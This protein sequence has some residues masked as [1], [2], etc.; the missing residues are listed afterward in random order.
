M[1]IEKE[2]LPKELIEI[3]DS[4]EYEE[5]GYLDVESFDFKDE[6]ILFKFSLYLGEEDLREY[7]D[8]Q[9]EIKNYKDFNINFDNLNGYFKFHTNHIALRQYETPNY[10]LYFKSLG[11]D[12]EF[13]YMDIMKLHRDVFNNFISTK[14]IN[15]D[16]FMLCNANSGLFAHGAKPILE[17]YFDC[18]QKAGKN[19]YFYKPN[20]KYEQE[21]LKNQTYKL[22]SLGSIYFIGTDFVFRKI[23]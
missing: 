1:D 11:T 6:N 15:S 5:N 7:Q 18:L 22:I 19:P 8:W 10:E 2:F 3:F 12:A 21:E 20:I 17:Y 13:L 9:I 14:Y 4:L 16:L 23:E